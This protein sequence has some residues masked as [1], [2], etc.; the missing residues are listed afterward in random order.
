MKSVRFEETSV[1]RPTCRS[2]NSSCLGG[3]ARLYQV[4]Q[5]LRREKPDALLLNA[6]DSFQGTYWY[7][8]LKWNVTQ[9]FMNMLP[10]DAH[11]LGNHEFDDGVAGL[12]PYMRAL[13]APVIAANMDIEREPKLAGLYEPHVVVERGGR[14]I[15]L[16]GLI[17]P[18]TAG[19]SN[20]HMRL[21][22]GKGVWKN[23]EI[24]QGPIPCSLS[25]PGNVKF[26]DPLEAVERESAALIDKG[27]DIIVVLSHCGLSVDKI[28]A[29]DHGKNVDVIVGGHSHSLLWNGP[30]PSDEAV[31][32]PYPVTVQATADSEHR[33][34]IVQASAFTKYIG[35]LSVYFD[36]RGEYVKWDGG[37]MFLNRSYPEDEDIKAKLAPFASLVHEAENIKI[38]ETKKTLESDDCVFGECAIGDVLTDALNERA[39]EVVVSDLDYL[40]FIQRGNIKFPL[41]EGD[42]TQGDLFE[43]L[44]YYDRVESFELRGR[45]VLAALEH[46]V[47]GAWRISPFKGPWV[48]Q[49]SGLFVTYNVSLEEG[50]R[51]T[52]VYIGDNS[53]VELDLDKFYQVTAPA[54]LADGGDNFTMFKTEKRNVK[55]I[56]RDQDLVDAYIKKYSPLDPTVEGRIKINY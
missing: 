35:N 32:G 7:T 16:I 11:A 14:R 39:K 18:D 33:V 8:L 50:A 29:R 34:L 43:V 30:A 36:Y 49:V 37:P 40:A 6:G 54:F 9:H 44:P 22:K 48:L 13:D 25:S 56:G 47:A 24:S 52:S 45:D 23:H 31:A 53:T 3:F 27:V 51:V 1:R 19:S 41:V 17:T 28:I 4:I 5:E 20:N 55:Y 21:K 38:G 12:E 2:N 10:H 46:G 15:G 42:I 26:T